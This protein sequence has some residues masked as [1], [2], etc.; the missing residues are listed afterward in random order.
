MRGDVRRYAELRLARQIL[1][2][3]IEAYRRQNQGPLLEHAG[4]LFGELTRG[5]VSD[6]PR[7][8]RAKMDA[9][10]WSP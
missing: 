4:Q 2:H 5:R 10:V 8:T 6:D 1:E 7:P 9:R 3:E